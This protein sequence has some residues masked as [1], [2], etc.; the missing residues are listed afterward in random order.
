V[1]FLD[2]SKFKK[3]AESIYT[4]KIQIKIKLILNLQ[5]QKL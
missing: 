2:V 1:E 5:H 4:I 3:N